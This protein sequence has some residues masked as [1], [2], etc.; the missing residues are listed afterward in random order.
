MCEFVCV[1]VCLCVFVWVRS[2]VSVRD[3]GDVS[4]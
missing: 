4:V 2:C 1:C 3:S